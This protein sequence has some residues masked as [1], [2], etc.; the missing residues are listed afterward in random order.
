MQLPVRRG[1]G[2]SL[3][4][5]SPRVSRGSEPAGLNQ[6]QDN[7]SHSSLAAATYPAPTLLYQPACCAVIS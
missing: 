1:G 2:S 4:P 3:N 7:L 6:N 5:G